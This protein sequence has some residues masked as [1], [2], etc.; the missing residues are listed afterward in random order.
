MNQD[1]V[2]F[3][4]G[5]I[6]DVAHLVLQR[7]RDQEL[8]PAY[9]NWK[10]F[11]RISS[12]AGGFFT[13]QL[14]PYLEELLLKKQG[15]DKLNPALWATLERYSKFGSSVCN[16]NIEGKLRKLRL[17]QEPWK[18]NVDNL[19]PDLTYSDVHEFFSRFGELRSIQMHRK[20]WGYGVADVTFQ[21][22]FDAVKA[23]E[24]CRLHPQAEDP[25]D[26][27]DISDWRPGF[28]EGI[29]STLAKLK[30]TNLASDITFSHI[31]RL[32]SEFG[33]ILAAGVHH[34]KSG[35]S[36]GTAFV[37]FSQWWDAVNAMK[38][39]NGAYIDGQPMK[40]YLTSEDYG[41]FKPPGKLVV[42]N[43]D[44]QVTYSSIHAL[45]S[46]VGK[47]RQ[48]S[49]QF[50]HSG[51]SLGT[52]VVVFELRSV[53]LKAMKELNGFLLNG[54]PIQ[55]QHPASSALESAK[56]VPG[57]LR[58]YGTDGCVPHSRLVTAFSRF[59]KLRAVCLSI[60]DDEDFADVVFDRRSKA[61]KALKRYRG[62][63]LRRESVKIRFVD[64]I[65]SYKMWPKLRLAKPT[66]RGVM[67]CKLHRRLR[68]WTR[69]GK[70]LLEPEL[71]RRL[72][73]RSVFLN[74]IKDFINVSD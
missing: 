55:I 60:E 47:L 74:L 30:V 68:G 73:L 11:E 49:V 1:L 21:R 64:H 26:E 71:K 10:L 28:K 40:I 14:E 16:S 31:N 22:R 18:L 15:P 33:E 38:H 4:P 50:N 43:L 6:L 34:D 32:F 44:L 51:R 7:V 69:G 5:K 59:G 48:V 37:I 58:I 23:V 46:T 17:D 70:R 8:L 65:Y 54:R 66:R 41:F 3:F 63:L 13:D 39:C 61:F 52:A 67:G 20:K 53:A 12:S 35:K 36:L 25:E 57:K 9:K 56:S 72:R 27:W 45:F 29:E 42:A 62:C 2:C 24:F 19:G